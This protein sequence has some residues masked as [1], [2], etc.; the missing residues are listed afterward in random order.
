MTPKVK[1]IAESMT[2][3]QKNFLL[4]ITSIIK[5]ARLESH[6]YSK[7]EDYYLWSDVEAFTSRKY[8]LTPEE[9]A[10]LYRKPALL[11]SYECGRNDYY[12]RVTKLGWAVARRLAHELA[13]ENGATVYDADDLWSNV[14]WSVA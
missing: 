10:G 9:Y 7:R 1:A 11:Q 13:A 14:T 5:M 4:Q 2:T 6:I 12:L 8:L 3:N